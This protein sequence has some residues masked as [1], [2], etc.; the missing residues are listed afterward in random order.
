MLLPPNI[1]QAIAQAVAQAIPNPPDTQTIASEVSRSIEAQLASSF[2]S[3]LDQASVSLKAD[4]AAS[5]ELFKEEVD[6]S[7]SSSK[8]ALQA[9]AELENEMRDWT[10]RDRYDLT[11]AQIIKIMRELNV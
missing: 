7:T 4:L 2:K 1:Q 3:V 11:R 5:L 10:N 9:V 8:A 6:K